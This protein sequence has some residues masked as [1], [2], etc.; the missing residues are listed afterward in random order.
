MDYKD[1]TVKDFLHDEL[2]RK[3]VEQPDNA[4]ELFWKTWLRE[5]PDHHSILEEARN[6][7]LLIGPEEHLPT[8][9][10]QAEVWSRIAYSIQEAPQ[11]R[12]VI[13]MWR[14]AA[15]F[16]G[17]IAATVAGWFFLHREQAVIVAYTTAYGEVQTIVLPDSTE[18]RLNAHSKLRGSIT[19]NGT[20]EVWLD[21]EGYFSVE[22]RHNNEP[23]LVHTSDVDVQVIGTEFNVNTRRVMTRVVLNNGA[24]KLKLN[25]NERTDVNMKPGEMVTYSTKTNQLSRRNVNPSDYS[26]WRD[27]ML[28]FNEASIAEVAAALQD[29]LGFNITI[30]DKEL[31]QELFT[32]SIPMSNVEVFFKT[33]SRSLNVVIEKKDNH[34]YSIRRK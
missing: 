9:E 11:K 19:K 17:V 3:W 21:G 32:G 31:Q 2:F 26:A 28:V 10:D 22:H 4:T 34:N 33:L 15:I 18:V 7:L 1:Y 27:N 6:V 23:F 12:R 29:N 8:A 13:T 20:R 16:T 14:Y 30:E 5:N 25:G 24:V